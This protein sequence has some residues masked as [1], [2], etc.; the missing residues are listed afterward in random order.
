MFSGSALLYIFF[1]ASWVFN[2][3]IYL[4]Y[5]SGTAYKVAAGFIIFS[6]GSNPFSKVARISDSTTLVP[7]IPYFSASLISWSNCFVTFLGLPNKFISAV[8][9]LNPEFCEAGNNG[10]NPSCI[11]VAALP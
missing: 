11:N 1:N 4:K 8:A 5:V 3:P 2:Q 10:L 6:T 9:T 7:L